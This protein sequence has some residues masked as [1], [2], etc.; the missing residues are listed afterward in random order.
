MK[1]GW[2]EDEPCA[3]GLFVDGRTRG[4][5]VRGRGTVAD[6]CYH[7]VRDELGGM[8]ED[9]VLDF[10]GGDLLSRDF[11]GILESIDVAGK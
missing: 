1:S 9:R 6:A 3:R 2:R 11:E 7:D 10:I 5:G 8:V 4:R